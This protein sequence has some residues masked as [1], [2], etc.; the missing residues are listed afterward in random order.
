MM[1]G[2][3]AV[4]DREAR[5]ESLE[6]LEQAR[7]QVTITFVSGTRFMLKKREIYQFDCELHI[8]E[9]DVAELELKIPSEK[10]FNL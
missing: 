7:N 1:A 6:Y 2:L 3:P 9:R 10:E 8:R 5:I 4:A